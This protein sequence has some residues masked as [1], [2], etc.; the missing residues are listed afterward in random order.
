MSIRS[1]FKR[2][3]VSRETESIID[4]IPK[5]VGSFD[6]D[7][8]GYNTDA[9]KIAASVLRPLYEDYF[10][11]EAHGLEQVPARGRLLVIANH[12]GQLPFDGSLV[13]YAM[14]TNPHHPR[15]VRVMVE[16]W[17]PTLPYV[18]NLFNELGGVLGDPENCSKML[19]NEE[20]IVVFPEG[21]R[22]SGKTW[23]K[24]YQLQRFGLG[25]MHLRS[26]NRRRC[27]RWGSWDARRPCPRHFI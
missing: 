11:V 20:A 18:G 27:C 21:V 17:F 19:R 7:P 9:V 5:P 14:T 13:A 16:R 8:W 22:G 12:S 6:Y 26:V 10:R 1:F 15:A 2:M 25:F 24:R 4:R 23:D 3:L